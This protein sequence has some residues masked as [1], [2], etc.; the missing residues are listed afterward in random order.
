MTDANG[1]S[2]MAHMAAGRKASFCSPLSDYF[3]R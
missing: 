2:V 3:K 1:N